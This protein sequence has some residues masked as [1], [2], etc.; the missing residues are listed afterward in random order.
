MMMLKTEKWLHSWTVSG[1]PIRMNSFSHREPCIL[2]RMW[3][4]VCR[5]ILQAD[6]LGWEAM[7]PKHSIGQGLGWE[8]CP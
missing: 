7:A 1:L 6:P 3:A 5:V 8:S 4:E 2:P